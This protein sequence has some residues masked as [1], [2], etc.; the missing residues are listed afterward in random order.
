[1]V[2]KL[3]ISLSIVW[4]CTSLSSC[5]RAQETMDFE[6]YDPVSTLVVREHHITRAKFARSLAP[7]H[8]SEPILS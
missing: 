2:N 4:A 6:K 5:S 1:M 3:L 8:N 7:N